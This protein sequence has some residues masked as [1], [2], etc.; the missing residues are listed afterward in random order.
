MNKKT[1][2]PQIRRISWLV[3]SVLAVLM[4]ALVSAF[5]QAMTL[6]A[7]LRKRVAT[8]EPLLE[9]QRNRN[10]TLQAQL[11][12]VQSDTYVEGWAQEQAGMTRPGE[13]LIAPLSA[14][15]TPTATPLPTPAPVG[16]SVPFWVQWWQALFGE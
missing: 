13:T 14:T 9:E 2:Q 11:D 7:T 3:W 6:N 8:L 1:E 4:L 10:G 16:T 5:S 12:Y 15:M